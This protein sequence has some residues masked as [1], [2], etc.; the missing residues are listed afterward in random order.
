[1]KSKRVAGRAPSGSKPSFR[2][3]VEGLRAIAVL[4]V[5]AYHAEIPGF[6]GGF[7]GVDIFFVL[8]G[9]LIT[10]LLFSELLSTTRISFV[11]FYARRARRLLPAAAL[12]I[13]ATI[14][15]AHYLLSPLEQESLARTALST[16][17]YVSNFHFAHNASDYFAV[18]MSRNPLLHT[19]SLAVEEQF[20]CVWPLLLFLAYKVRRSRRQVL[21]CIA[22]LSVISLWFCIWFTRQNQAAAFFLSPTRAWQFGVGGLLSLIPAY[23]IRR[24]RRTN[25]V[26][27]YSG[28]VGIFA[29]AF[30]YSSKTP[31]PGFAALLPTVATAAALVAGVDSLEH[32]VGRGLSNRLLQ[33][34]G[35][36][37]YSLYLWHWPVL[38]FTATVVKPF[39]I[40]TRI[41]CIGLSLAIAA[42]THYLYENPIR[43]NRYLIGRP[44]L[45]VSCAL[46]LTLVSATAVVGWR[47]YT[48]SRPQYGAYMAFGRAR[49]DIP[50][51]YALGCRTDLS[52]DAIKECHF[53]NP[54][55][56]TTVVLYG[57]SHAAQ[58]FPAMER[59]AG[60]RSWDLMTL[61]KSGCP[62]TPVPMYN[63][64]LPADAGL[65]NRWRISALRR[66]L[67]AHPSL[68]VI[69]S[70]SDYQKKGDPVEPL[71]YDDWR[72]GTT[73]ML[74]ELT[75]AGINIA[76]I[77]DIPRPGI[78]IPNCLAMAAWKGTGS[79]GPFLRSTHEDGNAIRGLEDA[80]RQFP[81][82]SVLNLSDQICRGEYCDAI[83]DGVVVYRD[84]SH[85]TATFAQ[86]M[87]PALA[88]R[89]PRIGQGRQGNEPVSS[90]MGR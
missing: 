85:L 46:A 44:R 2:P 84:D 71:T 62:A 65:C 28:L 87:M 14:V 7:I 48:I 8:S 10:G 75:R 54:H 82:V 27:G 73:R 61:V 76:L 59:L 39:T 81:G 74:E 5:V 55:S 13:F 11:S 43:F 12:T 16:V 58:W 52:E 57:D 20:Y 9:Y 38:V 50:R 23:K 37:S 67:T 64:E 15:A 56:S 69:S 60:E 45:S 68:L 77:E 90:G 32:G 6:R 41:A 83:R 89:L 47:R 36:L 72:N 63:A 53:G 40:G 34:I 19:W 88:A 78:D 49:N 35:G 21:G 4:L 3:D 31:F 29:S 51:I 42:G 80:A 26:L 25:Q 22:V 70:Y 86:S 24:F 17:M 33:W 1:M 66:I 30:L 18:D 79:C